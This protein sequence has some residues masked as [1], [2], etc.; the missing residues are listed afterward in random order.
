MEGWLISIK[1]V[2]LTHAIPFVYRLIGAIVLAVVGTIAIRAI[3]RLAHASLARRSLDAT[4][5]RYAESALDLSLKL[6]LLLTVFGVFGIETTSFAAVLAAVGI[7]IGAAWSGLLANFAAGVFLITLQPFKVGDLI[8]AGGVMGFVQ[9][10]GLFVTKLH[11][12][13]NVRVFIGNSRLLSETL[14]NLSVNPL[15][16]VD[17][18]VVLPHG[19]KPREAIRAL[20]ERIRKIPGVSETTPPFIGVFEFTLEGPLLVVRPFCEPKDYLSVYF[21]TT[22]AICDTFEAAGYPAP[23]Q[24]HALRRV[25]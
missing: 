21:E 22:L 16:R 19:I 13:S 5:A 2:L 18:K 9:E 25:A 3:R 1:T 17:L 12:D 6:L 23:E 15:V 24:R 20:G 10:V 4:L 11:T 8:I 7:A 14:Q